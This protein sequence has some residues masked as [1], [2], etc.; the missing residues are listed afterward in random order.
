MTRIGIIIGSTRPNRNGEQVARWVYDIAARR[1]DAEFELVDLRDYPLPHLDEPLPP[2]M[3]QYQNDHTKDWAA[4][5]AS[6][7][8]FVIVTPEYNH[9]TSGV[10][11]NAIDYLYAEWNNK[12]V[13]FVSYGAV[14]GARAAEH[15]RLVAGELQMADVRQQVTL[16]LATDFENYT[17]FKPGDYQ[18]AALTTLLDQVVAWSKALAP[19]R[20][21]AVAATAP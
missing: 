17:V 13:G 19:L 15:L 8:G 7:D 3:G 20:Q 1:T 9:G 14:G 6:F 5:I 12:A 18:V 2:S 4:T 11:K 16:S 21:P 10:L